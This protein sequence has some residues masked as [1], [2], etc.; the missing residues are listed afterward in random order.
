METRK[1][2]HPGNQDVL[3]PGLARVSTHIGSCTVM[4]LTCPLVVSPGRTSGLF[5]ITPA[6]QGGDELKGDP[7]WM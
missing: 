1:A 2:V 6:E 7:F 5:A 3:L 4:E